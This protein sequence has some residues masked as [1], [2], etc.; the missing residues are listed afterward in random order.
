MEKAVD[1]VVARRMRAW[2]NHDAPTWLL[3]QHVR[4][5]SACRAD[6]RAVVA[7]PLMQ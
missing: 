2:T 1:I 3:R 6:R 7:R 4:V 5:R